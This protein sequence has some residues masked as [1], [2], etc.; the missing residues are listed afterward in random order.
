MFF[1]LHCLFLLNNYTKSTVSQF[2]PKYRNIL[3]IKQFTL[4]T[5]S[6]LHVSLAETTGIAKTYVFEICKHII[7]APYIITHWLLLCELWIWL[8]L[9]TIMYMN[10]LSLLSKTFVI[11]RKLKLTCIYQI[12]MLELHFWKGLLNTKAGYYNKNVSLFEMRWVSW[13]EILYT[14]TCTCIYSCQIIWLL[15]HG[16]NTDL[17][18][19]YTG[20][21]D[22]YNGNICMISV[23][24]VLFEFIERWACI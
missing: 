18:N 23:L 5:L 2:P 19:N 9:C 17:Q 16:D 4:H 8:P 20:W 3:Y 10:Y 22:K 11:V 7:A 13:R 1:P 6:T 12:R 24:H 14:L 15:G 21:Y